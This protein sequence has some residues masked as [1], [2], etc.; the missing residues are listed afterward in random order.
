MS[1]EIIDK[2]SKWLKLIKDMHQVS[3]SYTEAGYQGAKKEKDSDITVAEVAI[4]N[5]F[6]THGKDGST[7]TPARPF[8]RSYY[9]ENVH[10]I[11]K[12]ASRLLNS[13]IS[14]KNNTRRALGLLGEFVKS[15]IQKQ[16][17]KVMLPALSDATIK[18]RRM[19][20]TKPLIDTGTMRAS[21]THTE[22]IKGE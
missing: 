1:S 10:Q 13:V 9:D 15:G 19:H 12:T 6:G 21:V 22:K 17:D 18:R 8:V 3:G 20:T 4:Y 5:E 7:H 2:N 11:T 14:G 16:I